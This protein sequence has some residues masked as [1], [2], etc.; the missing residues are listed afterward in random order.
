MIKL[1]AYNKQNE[2]IEIHEF[3]NMATL[4]FWRDNSCV[5]EV[6][7]RPLTGGGVDTVNRVVIDGETS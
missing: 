3:P 6:G 7:F 4:E 1:I 5:F 2:I